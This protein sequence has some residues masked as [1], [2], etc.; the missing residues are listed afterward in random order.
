M[1]YK[2]KVLNG[3]MDVRTVDG[4][5]R[6]VLRGVIDPSTLSDVQVGSYQREAGS[7]SDLSKL[8]TAIKAGEQL[9]DVEVGVRGD[10]G[11]SD[12]KGCYYIDAECFVVD[13][14]QRLTAARRVREELGVDFPIHLG[15]LFHIGTDEAWERAR[16]KVLNL[17][18]RRVS[19]NIILRNEV[20]S[21]SVQAMLAMNKD[22]KNFV[23]RGKI[24]W[25]QKMGRGE[26][27]TALAVFK[28]VGVLHSH[29]GPGLSSSV[30]QLVAAVDK[31][32]EIVGPNI[33]REN[34][35]NYFFSI[36][37]AF[38]LSTIAYRDLSPQL[39]GGFL[40][41]LARVFA[42]H[43]NFWDGMRFRI[44]P[45]DLMKL[46]QFP[47]RDP[48]IVAIANGTGTVIEPLYLKLVEHLNSYRRTNKLMKWNGRPAD[49]LV[50]QEVEQ[51]QEEDFEDT[52]PPAGE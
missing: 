14:L 22:G 7:L 26:L 19:P 40:R 48:G 3:A 21:P 30:E 34:I 33:W 37:Q 2:V 50:T 52:S 36:D 4:E 17:Y 6:L 27:L 31:T 13:G 28:V 5:D 38:G 29:F 41:T 32:Q 24:S 46:R 47:L 20:E 1:A 45:K 51:S 42:D 25:G 10:N 18:R 23:L 11:I 43:Q 16:F 44:D 49:G 35:R 39:K 12:R 9:P 15:A 8:I